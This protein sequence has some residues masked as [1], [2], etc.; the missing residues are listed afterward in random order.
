MNLQAETIEVTG[1]PLG[2]I[3]AL[4]QIGRRKGKSA[5][6]L[7][8]EM[9]E[10]EILATQPFDVILAS[11]RHGFQENGMTEEELDALFEEAR[12]EVYRER[13]SQKS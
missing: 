8:R 3:T 1:L 4:E 12:E 6:E 10:V 5:E 9:I 2:T 7:L 13:Q 11:I